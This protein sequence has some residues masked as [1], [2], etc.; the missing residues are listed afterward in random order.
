MADYLDD[1][2]LPFTYAE[3]HAALRVVCRNAVDAQASA[4]EYASIAAE[5]RGERARRVAAGPPPT[6]DPTLLPLEVLAAL[7]L[8]SP[9][10]AARVAR[11]REARLPRGAAALRAEEDE[12]WEEIVA[13][14]RGWAARK[15]GGPSVT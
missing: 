8:A 6:A 12:F 14:V 2:E 9:D 1:D 4:D 15:P 5:R 10:A 13:Q 11:I 7:S 3:L